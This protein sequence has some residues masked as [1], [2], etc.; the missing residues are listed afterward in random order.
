MHVC[1]HL[2]KHLLPCYKSWYEWSMFILKWIESTTHAPGQNRHHFAD[3]F[4]CIFM[5]ENFCTLI[6]ISLKFVSKGPIESTLIQIMAWRRTGDK[7]LPEPILTQFNDAYMPHW[8][9]MAK[10]HYIYMYCHISLQTQAVYWRLICDICL[11]ISVPWNWFTFW[12][13]E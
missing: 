2:F 6:W 7:P 3:I 1:L 9:E 8:G 12:A 10:H 13:F 11:S 5:N 4:K